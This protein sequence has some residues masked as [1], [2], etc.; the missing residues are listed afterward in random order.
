MMNNHNNQ[1]LSK[2]KK[3]LKNNKID[4][5]KLFKLNYLKNIK[6]DLINYYL[7]QIIQNLINYKIIHLLFQKIN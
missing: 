2:L 4:F 6:L 1:R 5:M 7:K 3:M